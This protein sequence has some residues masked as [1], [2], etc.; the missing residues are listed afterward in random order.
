MVV[1]NIV[2]GADKLIRSSA[3]EGACRASRKHQSC[4]FKEPT[5]LLLSAREA[6]PRTNRFL[7]PTAYCLQP[8]ACFSW[9]VRLRADSP[10]GGADPRAAG[11]DSAPKAGDRTA[12]SGP[13]ERR[14]KKAGLQPRLSAL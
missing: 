13:A 3:R 10:A 4:R 11:G 14:A 8:I 2:N 1:S 6:S 9:G 7:P 5:G 12:D